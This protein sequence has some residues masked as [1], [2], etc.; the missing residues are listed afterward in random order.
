M[1]TKRQKQIGELLRRQFSMV[2]LEEG[3]YIFGNALV[4][5]T[6]VIVSPDLLIAKV[7][8]SVYNAENKQE[9][10]LSL[11]EHHH[12]LRQALAVKIGKQLRRMPDI[13][14]FLDESLDE[15]FR[16]DRLLNQLRADHQMGREE[17]E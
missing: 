6:R 8:L 10:M 14:F 2:L 13:K 17:E 15:F 3:A 5:V 7:Y 16:M 11:D 12:Q 9:V 4:T 1:E